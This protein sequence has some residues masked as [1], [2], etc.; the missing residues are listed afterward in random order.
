MCINKDQICKKSC[1]K[2]VQYV[3]IMQNLCKNIQKYRHNMHR[4]C[5]DKHNMHRICTDIC[6]DSS[7]VKDIVF[8]S[9]KL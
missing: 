5:K 4:I 3:K 9:S 7:V 2:Y 8:M 6:T 1:K